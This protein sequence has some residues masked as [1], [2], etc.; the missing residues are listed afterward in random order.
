MMDEAD[1]DDLSNA[2]LARDGEGCTPLL[3]AAKKG[4]TDVTEA[5]ISSGAHCAEELNDDSLLAEIVDAKDNDGNSS[6][7][8]AARKGWVEVTMALLEARASVN[9]RNAE[10]ATPLHWA[11]RKNHSDLL[12]LLLQAGADSKL[13]NKWGATPLDQ[14]FAFSQ[15]VSVEALQQAEKRRGEG[16]RAN[17]ALAAKGGTIGLVERCFEDELRSS[18]GASFFQVACNH[19]SM[20]G[21]FQLARARN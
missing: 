10:G 11:A 12:E 1:T 13:I 18:G 7:H 4:F 9:S 19:L 5:L 8:W 6:L 3:I 16:A 14:A 2:I 21:G 20:S 15:M 17:A